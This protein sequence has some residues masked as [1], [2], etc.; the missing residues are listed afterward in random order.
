MSEIQIDPPGASAIKFCED[1]SPLRFLAQMVQHGRRENDVEALLPQL[2]FAHIALD[3]LN[4]FGPRGR[5]SLPCPVQHRLAEVN[6]RNVKL[7]QAPKH[8]KRIIS[9]PATDIEQA[10]RS[11]RH[12]CRGRSHHFQNQR[13]IH[14]RGLPRLQHRKTLD[15]PIEPARISSGVDFTTLL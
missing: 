13:R 8:L 9:R 14:G 6:Q 11:R 2:D 7:R 15:F 3:R 1:G 10:L 12:R 5:D 4:F